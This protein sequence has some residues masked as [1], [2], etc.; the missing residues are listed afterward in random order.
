MNIL[1]LIIANT[2]TLVAVFLF[3]GSLA[4]ASTILTE[5]NSDVTAKRKIIFVAIF[6]V[7]IFSS[8]MSYSLWRHIGAAD[9]HLITIFYGWWI[10]GCII[11]LLMLEHEGYLG[12]LGIKYYRYDPEW[13]SVL[14]VPVAGL[15]G[16]LVL[17]QLLLNL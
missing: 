14:L 10:I 9:P 5:P 4:L 6:G 12:Y 15:F 3:M 13:S 1:W 11:K 2:L 16:P 17:L 8:Y 7:L